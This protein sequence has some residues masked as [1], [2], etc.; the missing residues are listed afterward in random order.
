MT[1]PEPLS[2]EELTR[3]LH[4]RGVLDAGATVTIE[5]LAGGVSGDVCAVAAPGVEAVVKRAHRQLRVAREWLA[6]EDRLVTEGWALRLAGDLIPGAVPRVLDLD[7]CTRTLVMERAP[8]DWRDWRAELLAG[9]V[10]PAVGERLGRLLRRW[11]DAS[12]EQP[13]LLAAFA[14]QT[15]FVQLRIDPFHRAVAA[16]HPDLG[17]A[18]E[19]VAQ[20]LL[21]ERRCLVHGDF[22]P[23]NVLVGGDG[24]WVVDW[25]VAH[26]GAPVFDLAFLVC[27]LVLKSVH[28]PEQAAA[29]RETARRFLG[30]YGA[31]AERDLAEHVACL[32]LARVDGTSPAAYLTAA[33]QVRVRALGRRMLGS[34]AELNPFIHA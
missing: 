32:L 9:R 24:A 14:D 27:H 4:A 25:E 5:P 2:A 22:S 19:A 13:R 11:H 15:A 31:D 7:P 21:S 12:A 28:R 29:C 3:H 20:R 26:V 1:E 33:Q 34:P 23:K 8:R 30:G 6:D 16:R 18:I 10:D 17:G